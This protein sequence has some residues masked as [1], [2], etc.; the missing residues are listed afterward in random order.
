VLQQIKPYI[1]LMRLDKPIG[2][3]LLLW[4]TLIALWLA[5]NGN[6]NYKIVTIF[7]LG[8]IIMRAAGCVIND[9]ADRDIDLFV[10]RTKNRPLTTGVISPHR[11][12]ALFTILMLCAFVLVMHLNNFTIWLSLVAVALAILYPY[13]K[14][15]TFYPQIILGLAF[16]WSIPMAYAAS[17]NSLSIETWVLYVA[18]LLW[19]VAYDTQYAMADKSDDLRIGIKSTAIAFGS[20]D[21]LIIFVLQMLSLATFV[22]LGILYSLRTFYY[23]ALCVAFF[24]FVYQQGLIKER[25]PQKCI[26]AF[27]NNNYVGMVIFLGVLTI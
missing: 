11:A 26:Q 22:L 8:V 18:N 1:A 5:R 24:L 14:R 15:F 7:V 20:Y 6:P 25:L 23:L 17:R 13:A 12:R 4:P 19:V 2:T 10:E 16:S 21:K 27:L 9:Y 3:L